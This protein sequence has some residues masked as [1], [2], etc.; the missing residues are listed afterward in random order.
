LAANPFNLIEVLEVAIQIAE[1]LE[2][3]HRKGIVHRDIKSANIMVN[4]KNRAKIMDF[5]LAKLSS[6]TRFTRTGMTMG[7]LGY[8]SPEQAKGKTTDHRTDIFSFGIVLYE[9]ITS[10]LPFKGENDA[11]MLHSLLYEEP[12]PLLSHLQDLPKEW[13]WVIDKALSKDLHTR[14]QSTEE[15]LS[16]LKSLQASTISG[17]LA[18]PIQRIKRRKVSPLTTIPIRFWRR[19]NWT[20]RIGV[21]LVLVL[22]TFVAVI[23]WPSSEGI[24]PSA[25]AAS[26]VALP[27]QVYGDSEENFLTDAIPSTLST[28]L[29]GVDWLETKVPPTS[30]EVEQ[31]KG[32]LREI[33]NA[34]NVKMCVISTVTVESSALILNIQLVEP[35]TKKVLWGKMYRGTQNNYLDLTREAAKGILQA[36]RP[37]ITPTISEVEH[38]TNSEAEL[39]FRR[40]QYYSNRYNNL[41]Q[42]E[43]Y[44]N[45]FASFNRALELDTN[46]A[47]AAAEIAMLF[48]YKTEKDMQP[49]ETVPEMVF[50]A[51]DALKIN[52]NC[53]KAWMALAAAEN[54]QRQSNWRKMLEYSFK[55]ASLIPMDSMAQLSIGQALEPSGSMY[56]ALEAYRESHRLDPLYLYAALGEP[57]ILIYLGQNRK[58]LPLMDEILRIEPDMQYALWFKSLILSDL[59]QFQESTEVLKKLEV[60]VDNGQFP[61]E[62]FQFTKNWQALHN[63]D[64][65]IV[66][67]SLDNIMKAVSSPKTSTLALSNIIPLTSR[68]LA[69]Q[70]DIEPALLI[71]TKG[72]ET[73]YAQYDFRYLNP[74]FQSLHGDPHFEE[75]LA[76]SKAKF[77]EMLEIL[78]GAQSRGEFPEYL[79]KPLDEL[80]NNLGR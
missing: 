44:E 17:E 71:L 25:E 58:A 27:A 45:A 76:Q 4:E 23:F 34:Y 33:G 41:A 5:G 6:A 11:S 47:D 53:G 73:G 21:G 55:A 72:L 54:W 77:D 64:I 49:Q 62:L 22:L 68:F 67:S 3:A 7:T 26:L 14:Y 48:E 65:E 66:R 74:D 57:V 18:A 29:G 61:P 12:D 8:M 70:G 16:D 19:S 9:L 80:L 2:E 56:L 1:G 10:Q 35:Q 39:A 30:F 38:T 63:Q 37:E 32:D 24:V 40:G 13:Q 75:I 31:V 43:D 15:M 51:R 20:Q 50:W 52:K 46:L 69:S 60:F 78:R 36:L 42:S 28:I 59:S 79:V